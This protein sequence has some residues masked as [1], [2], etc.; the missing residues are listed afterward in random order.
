M[1]NF[2]NHTFA[3]CA[4][5]ESSY[6]EE[7]IKSV[8]NQEV[9]SKVIICTATPNNFIK[10][11]AK[12]YKLDLFIRGG[13]PDIQDDWNFAYKSASTKY[14]TIT[15]QDDIYS[16]EYSKYVKR[17]SNTNKKQ[18]LFFSD[19][20]ELKDGRVIPLTINLKIK[21]IMLFPLRFKSLKSKKTIRKI[22]LSLGSPICC[23]AV[24]YNK[25]LISEK[26]FTS[27][28]KCSLD[29]DTWYKF[30]KKDGQFVYINKDLV[31]HRIHEESETTNAIESNVRQS[32]DYEMFKK[33]WPKPIAKIL[34]KAYCKSLNTN[35]ISN[36]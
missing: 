10:Y 23:P 3:I 26:P 27:T 5:K 6:L 11:M 20:R 33:F 8:I 32:E 2:N 18:L 30:S 35:N 7:C 17:Y 29:W 13:E 14:V 19:Y 24:T 31:Y 15:H 22:I 34:V 4:Y 16:R 1:E 28:M 9:K 25:E 21:N 12:K 36:K